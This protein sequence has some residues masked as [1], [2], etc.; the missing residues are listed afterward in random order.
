MCQIEGESEVKSISLPKLELCGAVLLARLAKVAIKVL[1][2]EFNKICYWSDSTITLCWLAG[3]PSLWKIF[4][5]NRVS[6]IQNATEKGQ[7][8]QVSSA[9]NPADIISR[10]MEP[11]ELIKYR[12]WWSGPTWLSQLPECWPKNP[13]TRN[14]LNKLPERRV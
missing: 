7:W 1:G 2:V 5:A 6:E 9:D 12:L 3:E 13:I 10:G 4:V 8:S 14:E 11:K